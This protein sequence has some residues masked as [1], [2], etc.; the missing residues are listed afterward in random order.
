MLAF[1]S[2]TDIVYWSRGLWR[3]TEPNSAIAG[4]WAPSNER[5]EWLAILSEARGRKA[6]MLTTSG[7]AELLFPGFEQPV[8]L[9]LLKG[10]MT[11]T[12]IQN[13]VAQ[14]SSADIV[15]VPNIVGTCGG[16]PEAPEFEAA[17]KKFDLRKEEYF[18]VYQRSGAD[19][20]R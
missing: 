9:F 19:A 7:A 2:R 11:P 20:R 4:L 3:T 10:L 12:E 14:I 13:K 18:D 15:V 1:L 8:S 17:M 5:A 16:I 6:V